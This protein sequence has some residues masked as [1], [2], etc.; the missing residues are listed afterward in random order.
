MGKEVH[1]FPNAIT[2]RS[3]AM[4]I[5]VVVFMFESVWVVGWYLKWAPSGPPID[6]LVYVI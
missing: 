5:E 3:R 4:T 1:V 6:S 2:L